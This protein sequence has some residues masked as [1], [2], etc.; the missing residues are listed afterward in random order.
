MAKTVI[1]IGLDLASDDTHFE[2]L[3]SKMSLLDWDIVLFKPD[4]RSLYAGCTDQ[5]KGRVRG[6]SEIDDG[7]PGGTHASSLSLED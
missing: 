1:T 2:D 5:Y 7:D 3:E 4:M 6:G